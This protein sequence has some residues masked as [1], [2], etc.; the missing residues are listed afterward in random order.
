MKKILLSAYACEPHRGSEA[1]IGWNWAIGLAKLKHTVWVLTRKNNRNCIEAAIQNA[2]ELSSLPLHF[3]YYDLPPWARWYKKGNRFIHLY[4][5]LWQW[6]AYRHVKKI[7]QT[8]AFDCV[9]HVTFVSLHQP[10]FMG[11]LNIPFIL[12][13]ISGGDDTPRALRKSYPLRG[14][15]WDGIRRFYLCYLRCDIFVR[16]MFNEARLIYVT[17]EA[18]KKLIPKPWQAKTH[19]QLAIG[20][21]KNDIKKPLYP[22]RKK[23]SSFRALY[24]GQFLYLKGMHLGLAAFARFCRTWSHPAQLTLIG[25]GPEEARWLKLSKTLGIESSV[26]WISWLPQSDLKLLY[27]E[28]DVLLYPSLHD[29]GAFVVLEALCHGLPTVSLDIG[30]PGI[31]VNDT[32][33]IKISRFVSPHQVIEDLSTALYQIADN[34]YL[35]HQLSMGALERAKIFN[36]DQKIR[37]IYEDLNHS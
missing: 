21:H 8:E 15:L 32:C 7:H 37:K 11:R 24:V 25:K 6:F 1:E 26:Q 30:G 28:Y 9:H 2:P 17:S 10:S 31:L 14:R 4:Y 36:W 19:I 16:Q 33:G 23:S 27:P 18:S 5:V 29:S 12:G 34:S 22:D 13:P 20:C 3:I 35:R